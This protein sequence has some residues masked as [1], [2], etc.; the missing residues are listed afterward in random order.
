MIQKHIANKKLEGKVEFN[1]NIL[2]DISDL[3]RL[4]PISFR[5][6]LLLIAYADKNNSI[7]TDIKTISEMLGIEVEKIKSAIRNLIKN[8]YI[9]MKEIKLNTSKDI[10]G[11]VHDKKLYYKSHKKIWKVIGEKFV[12]TWELNGTYNR[13]YINDNIVRCH[14]KQTNNILKHI[15]GNL[16]YD[17]RILDSEIIWEM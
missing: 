2:A 11:V 1:K 9:E 16:F 10:I 8:G 3:V 5:V 15:D 13:F 14:S 7:I 17:N 12:T 6:L 4:S